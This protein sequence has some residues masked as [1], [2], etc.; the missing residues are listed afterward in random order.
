VRL[1]VAGKHHHP[2][3]GV[4]QMT[5]HTVPQS[6]GVAHLPYRDGNTNTRHNHGNFLSQLQTDE[7]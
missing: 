1:K 3:S 2:W 6:I 4:V 7:T 5:L